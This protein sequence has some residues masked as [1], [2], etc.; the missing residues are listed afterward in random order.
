LVLQAGTRTVCIANFAFA[1]ALGRTIGI[2]EWN[3]GSGCWTIAQSIAPEGTFVVAAHMCAPVTGPGFR[4][5][6]VAPKSS[7]IGGFV[8][9]AQETAVEKTAHWALGVAVL[10]ATTKVRAAR[11]KVARPIWAS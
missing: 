7:R 11:N 8:G 1:P 6:V 3:F 5:G 2:A 9:C 10:A 4:R